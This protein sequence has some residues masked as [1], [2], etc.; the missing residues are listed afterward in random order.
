[1]GCIAS[2][3]K[4]QAHEIDRQAAI[5]CD[6]DGSGGCGDGNV[7]AASSR[8][9]KAEKDCVFC[10]IVASGSRSH[11]AAEGGKPRKDCVVWE[12]ERLVVFHDHKPSAAL[13]LQVVPRSHVKN[14]HSLRASPE[15]G[16]ALGE[17][18]G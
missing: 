5:A 3:L 16:H 18:T 8:Q 2:S 7:T 9:C 17:L 14:L 12:T 13:H 1:M 10:A 4:R 11:D 15:E 6:C